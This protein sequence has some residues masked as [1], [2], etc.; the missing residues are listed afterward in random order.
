MKQLILIDTRSNPNSY[1]PVDYFV[2]DSNLDIYRSLI[3]TP[4]QKKPIILKG[5]PKSGKT[6]IGRVW[7]SKYNARVIVD[8]C[9][10][11]HTS[12]YENCLVDDIDKLNTEEEIKALLHIY[13]SAV[14]N[15]KMLFMTTKSL[16]FS[17]A[18]PDLSSRLRA[19]VTYSMPP[20]DDEL[21]RVVARKQFYLYQN[22][23]SEKIIDLILHRVERS[24]EAVIEFITLLN[25][26]A[27]HKGKRLST[28]FLDEMSTSVKEERA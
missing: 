13:N 25:R 7:A 8:L 23:V 12:I 17:E 9:K 14:E 11:I 22:R 5:D 6:H 26:E 27:L 10:E 16:E 3:E 24:M 20:P 4:F 28:R 18:L 19:S 1:S 15:K 2:S 21:L